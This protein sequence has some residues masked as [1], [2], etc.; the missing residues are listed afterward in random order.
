MYYT[1]HP[2]NLSSIALLPAVDKVVEK[3]NLVSLRLA[4][5]SSTGP[6]RSSQPLLVA[7]LRKGADKRRSKKGWNTEKK[8]G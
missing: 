7:L 8:G 6:P 5:G 3:H 4:G 2:K 1:T